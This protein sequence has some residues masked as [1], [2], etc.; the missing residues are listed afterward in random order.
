[1]P[2]EKVCMASESRGKWRKIRKGGNTG[3][4]K[5]TH[6]PGKKSTL[7]PQSIGTASILPMEPHHPLCILHGT[8][9]SHRPS[10]V[11]GIT[12]VANKLFSKAQ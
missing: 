6:S 5:L 10:E 1:M 8:K 9:H 7:Y 12:S 11:C 4:P 3:N 2:L